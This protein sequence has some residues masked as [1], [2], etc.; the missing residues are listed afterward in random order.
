MAECIF[1]FGYN[2]FNPGFSDKNHI[3]ERIHGV[4]TKMS[5]S[6]ISMRIIGYLAQ[7]HGYYFGSN[8]TRGREKSCKCN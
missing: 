4:Y 2:L 7:C 8:V 5:Y 1:N 3:E 6:L